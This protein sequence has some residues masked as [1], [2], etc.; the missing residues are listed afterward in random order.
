MDLVADIGGT[1]TRLALVDDG[2][3]VGD[4]IRS[5]RNHTYDGFDGPLGAFL[6]EVGRPRVEA[7]CVAIA[8]TV[9]DDHARLTNRGWHVETEAIRQVAG[10]PRAVLLNDLAALGY[11]LPH[12]DASQCRTI[13]PRGDVPRRNGQSFVLGLGTGVNVA[14]SM[15]VPGGG[16]RVLEAEAGHI[17]LPATIRQRVSDAIGCD[18]VGPFPSVEELLSGRGLAALY[19]AMSGH[20]GVSAQEVMTRNDDTARQ[21]VT[22]FADSFARVLRELILLYLPFDGVF[23]AGSVA[24]SVM[25]AA[26]EPFLTTLS[27]PHLMQANIAAP[28]VS[29]ILDD[30]AAL[31][32]CAARLRSD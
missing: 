7:A 1:N 29:L 12:L 20:S 9:Q 21:C 16:Y 17:E 8:G 6:A 30:A 28:S 10:T 5:Y 11:A 15:A 3:P 4:S 22:L 2:R 31:R 25:E 32:G 19:T 27:E 24:R 23:L 18:A 13:R 14:V 26:P